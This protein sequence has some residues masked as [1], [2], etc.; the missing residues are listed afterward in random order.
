MKDK[1]D[2]EFQTI[3]F[4][5]EIDFLIGPPFG[6]KKDTEMCAIISSYLKKRF[7]S[8]RFKKWKIFKMTRP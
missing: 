1:K 4:E 8:I 6:F 3:G 5:A 2:E 7:P